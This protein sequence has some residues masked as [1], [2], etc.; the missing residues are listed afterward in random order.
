MPLPKAPFSILDTETGGLN[1]DRNPLL[2][3]G[4]VYAMDEG[5]GDQLSI[6]FKP[7]EDTWLELPIHADQLKGKNDKTIEFWLNLTTGERQK[8][9]GTKPTKL[10]TAVAAEV[11]GFVGSSETVPGWDM[12]PTILWGTDTYITGAA[13]IAEWIKVH[14]STAVLCHNASF[15]NKF[16]MAWIPEL[17]SVLPL[18]WACTQR[19]YKEAFLNGATKGS[20]IGAICKVAGINPEGTLH[21]ELGDCGA[22][23]QI[24][25]WLRAQGH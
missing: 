6:R 19:V 13:R 14:P 12:G 9:G 10:I 18:E 20:S 1:A 16:I 17:M 8:P 23:Y 7:P 4:M 2:S 22:T 5:L 25:R 11:N 15:D 3:I 21:T 24:W